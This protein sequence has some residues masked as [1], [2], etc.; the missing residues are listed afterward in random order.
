MVCEKETVLYF[1]IFVI[2]VAAGGLLGRYIRSALLKRGIFSRYKLTGMVNGFL[3]LLICQR[4]GLSAESLLCCLCASLLL[5]VAAVD[6]KAFEIPVE[7][8]LAIGLL[9]AARL[10]LAPENL[11]ECFAGMAAAGGLFL[12]IFVITEGD[13]IGGGDIK[14]MAAAGFFLGGEKVLLALFIGSA[15]GALCAFPLVKL[16]GRGRY[17]AYGPFLSFGIVTAMLYG[18]KI[19][20]RWL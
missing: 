16:A 14:L 11:A 20:N 19:I 1:S 4:E 10:F 13:G 6:A 12:V 8:N 7:C 2:A 5:A 15:L 9:G 3:W 18:D 17:L